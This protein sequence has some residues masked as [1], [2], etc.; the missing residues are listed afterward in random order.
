MT[1]QE[2]ALAQLSDHIAGT[3]YDVANEGEP[4]NDNLYSTFEE[5]AV[6]L[7]S[8]FDIEITK[9]SPLE[10]TIRIKQ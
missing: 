5:V 6:S 2:D 8:T 1:Q 4:E 9:A 7:L 10:A 3:L